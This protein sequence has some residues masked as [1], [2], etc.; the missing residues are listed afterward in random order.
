MKVINPKDIPRLASIVT[1]IINSQGSRKLNSRDMID[2]I[3]DSLSEAFP[4][5]SVGDFQGLDFLLNRVKNESHGLFHLLFVPNHPAPSMP[6]RAL[7]FATTGIIISSKVIEY[8]EGGKP[9][10]IIRVLIKPA[11]VMIHEG[12][13]PSPLLKGIIG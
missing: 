6:C 5:E 10:Q 1:A 3:H 9:S 4:G 13:P 2:R 8:F 11:I 12:K 7:L